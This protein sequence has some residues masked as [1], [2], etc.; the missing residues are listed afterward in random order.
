[1]REGC[2]RERIWAVGSAQE[3][4]Q[5]ALCQFGT[6]CVSL[7]SA[8]LTATLQQIL[9]ITTYTFA[10]LIINQPMNSRIV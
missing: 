4:T 2:G 1:M 8:A 7:R 10:I 3:L 6:S 9:L 5:R